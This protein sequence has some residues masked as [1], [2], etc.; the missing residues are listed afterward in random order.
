MTMERQR[1]PDSRQGE[2]QEKPQ[3]EVEV[4]DQQAHPVMLESHVGEINRLKIQ[5]KRM[6]KELTLIDD[7]LPSTV[8][9][10]EQVIDEALD[11][12]DVEGSIT[13]EPSLDSGVKITHTKEELIIIELYKLHG[14]LDNIRYEFMFSEPGGKKKS[15]D[16]KEWLEEWSKVLFDFASISKRHIIYV[17]DL[18]DQEPFNKLR[19][20]KETIDQVC[21]HM[22]KKE[23]AEWL[24]KKEK[25]RVYWKT[26]DE[27]AR[28]I[29]QWAYDNMITEPLFIF[30]L[31]EAGEDFSTIPVEEFEDI[32]K[33]LEKQGKGRVVKSSEGK[34]AF[35]FDF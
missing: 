34:I 29:Y 7:F 15:D 12:G 30:N 3:P 21:K 32:F 25:L 23:V 20:R 13:V 35:I 5:L 8:M 24:K 27:W 26:L 4:Q 18:L 19:K 10:A 33:I 9:M 11:D 6:L 16:Y 22:V 31:K 28:I 17:Q 14:W 1:Q 2:E